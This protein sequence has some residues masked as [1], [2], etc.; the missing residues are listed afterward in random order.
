MLNTKQAV[1]NFM[2]SRFGMMFFGRKTES[3]EFFMGSAALAFV[4]GC[5]LTGWH[6]YDSTLFLIL[7]HTTF[8]L[9]GILQIATSLYYVSSKLLWKF[10]PL[11]G[12]FIWAHVLYIDINGSEYTVSGNS[13]VYATIILAQWWLVIRRWMP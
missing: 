4:A 3:L 1:M 9:Y 7:T 13:G 11:L 8:I 12:M 5:T 10:V 6:E 2:T